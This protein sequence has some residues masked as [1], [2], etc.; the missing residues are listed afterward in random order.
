MSIQTEEPVVQ[1][2]VSTAEA[3]AYLKKFARS[4]DRLA[5]QLKQNVVNPIMLAKVAEV[6]PQMIYNYIRSGAIKAFEND[7]QKKVIN[8]DDA[9][10]FLRSRFERQAREAAK[11]TAQLAS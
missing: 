4:N 6:V 11:I 7:T 2:T 10:E 8:V 9:V 1:V 3:L 5:E